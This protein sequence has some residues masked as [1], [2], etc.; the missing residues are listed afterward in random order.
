MSRRVLVA[1]VAIAVATI[2][3]AVLVGSPDPGEES[4]RNTEATPTTRAVGGE[5]APILLPSRYARVTA[6]E[7]T[8]Y[9]LMGTWNPYQ[10]VLMRMHVIRAFFGLP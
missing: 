1:A 5:Y 9:F 10:V 2:A 6:E 4:V 7:S 3:W 8:L